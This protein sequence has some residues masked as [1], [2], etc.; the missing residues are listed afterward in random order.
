MSPPTSKGVER[1]KT[2]SG[3]GKIPTIG[4]Y[5]PRELLAAPG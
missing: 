4:D 5:Q 2:E 1:P 3:E